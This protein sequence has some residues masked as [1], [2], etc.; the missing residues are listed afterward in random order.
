MY[1]TRSRRMQHRSYIDG[2]SGNFESGDRSRQKVPIHIKE[3]FE[4]GSK[5]Q[6]NL[7]I[8]VKGG[9]L[10]L[11]RGFFVFCPKSQMYPE[12]TSQLDFEAVRK[13]ILEFRVIKLDEFSA[14]V[15][16]RK[17]LEN[18]AWA[19]IHNAM[20]NNLPIKG[21]VKTFQHYGIFVDIGSI[22]GLLHISQIPG[23]DKEDFRKL[24]PVG[25]IL[26]VYVLAAN[27]KQNRISLSLVKQRK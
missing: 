16:R 2:I 7:S 6:G 3:A 18:Q 19:N 5:I 13:K 9:Y 24:F 10:V 8:I 4:R 27:R 23:R 12:I 1:K 17:A 20:R 21:K 25:Q 14:V 11:S 15:S 26:R 22:D